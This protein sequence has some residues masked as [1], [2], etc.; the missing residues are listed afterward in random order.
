MSAV[1]VDLLVG[2][3]RLPQAACRGRAG[4]FDSHQADESDAEVAHRHRAAVD[5]CQ[6]CS[7]LNA[8]LTWLCSLPR[9][10]RPAGIVAG[11]MVDQRGHIEP[12]GRSTAEGVKSA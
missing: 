12:P 9:D 3:P 8:C 4:L 2:A 11:H 5:L 1:L 10:Q 6:Q 7:A